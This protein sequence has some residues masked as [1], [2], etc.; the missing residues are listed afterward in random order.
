MSWSVL[1]R[2]LVRRT[3]CVRSV[4]LGVVAAVF[5]DFVAST[6]VVRHDDV[7]QEGRVLHTVYGHVT[8]AVAAGTSAAPSTTTEAST[9][10]APPAPKPTAAAAARRL[11]RLHDTC[12]LV[13]SSPLGGAACAREVFCMQALLK[14]A[15][16]RAAG[17][18][19]HAHGASSHHGGWMMRRGEHSAALLLA[20]SGQDWPG[21]AGLNRT[22]LAVMARALGCGSARW[23][24]KGWC[25]PAP[26]VRL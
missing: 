17:R 11:A 16:T 8:P 10:R 24:G 26:L 19:L 7:L 20:K 3:P 13:W 12:K 22:R 9:A 6:V 18:P 21:V 1:A 14:S 15:V 4:R 25:T 5:A 23:E 2:T